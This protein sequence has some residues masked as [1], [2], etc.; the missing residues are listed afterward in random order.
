MPRQGLSRLRP[1]RRLLFSSDACAQSQAAR[2]YG[3]GV[4]SNFHQCRAFLRLHEAE[5][6]RLGFLADGSSGCGAFG[7]CRGFSVGR[8][9]L[10]KVVESGMGGGSVGEGLESDNEEE[11][12]AASRS[13]DVDEDD[14]VLLES[15]EEEDLTS[16]SSSEEDLFTCEGVGEGFLEDAEPSVDPEGRSYLHVLTVEEV[17]MVLE[18][19]RADD[20]QVIPVRDL[21]EW[22]DHLIIA[23]GHSGRHLRGIAEAIC[24]EVKKRSTNVGDNVYPTVEGR[25]SEE[26]MV[27]DC[28]SIVVHV[29]RED[30]RAEYNLEEM[31]RKRRPV[32]IKD[33]GL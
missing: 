13:G 11:A 10:E 12:V 15:V 14:E 6:A 1:L 27:V 25:E 23:S 28:G 2:G 31:W 30:I 5:E 33:I 18:K 8:M 21:C 19:T 16:D 17:Q 3:L 22:A 7:F 29:F 9:E 32:N 26:W 4:K 20:V 24:F